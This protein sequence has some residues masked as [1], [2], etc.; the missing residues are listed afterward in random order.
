MMSLYTHSYTL[1]NGHILPAAVW[2]DG[3]YYK[4]QFYHT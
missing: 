1:T 3:N 4:V 2:V